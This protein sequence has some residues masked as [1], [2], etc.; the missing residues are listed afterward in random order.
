MS[1][2]GAH[3]LE[4]IREK[5][6][7]YHPI[8]AIADIAHSSDD[9]VDSRLKYDCHKTIAKYVEPELKAIELKVGADQGRRVTISLFEDNKTALIENTSSID[10]LID[11]EYVEEEYIER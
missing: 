11:A 6:P 7:N 9:D 10:Q 8:V 3:V 1:S 4:L 5:Y 2:N